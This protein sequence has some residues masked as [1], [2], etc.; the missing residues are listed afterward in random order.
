FE[1]LGM[2]DTGFIVPPENR[3]RRAT[4]YGFDD[5]EKLMPRPRGLVKSGNAGKLVAERPDTMTYV[6]GGQGLWSTV[7]DYLAF[8]RLFLDDGPV[9]NVRL[10][11]PETLAMMRTNR[12]TDSQREKATLLGMSVFNAHGFGLGVAV[13]LDPE[14]ASPL[15]CRGGIGTVGW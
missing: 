8:A 13:V 3:H 10:L 12:L 6:S 15:R 7:D 1:P 14:K 5:S 4:M 9:D 11:R 2:K